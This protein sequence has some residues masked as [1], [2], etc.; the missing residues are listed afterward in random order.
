[1]ASNLEKGT[2]EATHEENCDFTESE[3]EDMIQ[4]KGT[5]DKNHQKENKQ[6]NKK[7]RANK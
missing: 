1:M 4:T 3:S 6:K 7:K 2:Q 5:E